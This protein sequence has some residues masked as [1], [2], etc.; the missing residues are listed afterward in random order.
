MESV[1]VLENY[2]DGQFVP[3]GR[4]IDS[5]NPA[6]GHVFLRVPDS[7]PDEVDQA[8]Q[9]AKRAFKK[10]ACNAYIRNL[11]FCS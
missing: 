6:T 4:H 11:L 5:Y 8:V 3:C 7:G 10:L 9:A 2:I 1:K